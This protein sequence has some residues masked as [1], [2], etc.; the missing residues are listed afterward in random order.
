MITTL[1]VDCV[2]M[3]TGL[4]TPALVDA[5]DVRSADVALDTGVTEVPVPEASAAGGNVSEVRGGFAAE[6]AAGETPPAAKAPTGTFNPAAVVV[7]R[8]LA[9][10]R[11]VLSPVDELVIPAEEKP[12]RSASLTT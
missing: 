11:T 3:R 2:T 4:A 8:T 1:P 12:I 7:G 6:T 9:D 10:P 5:D